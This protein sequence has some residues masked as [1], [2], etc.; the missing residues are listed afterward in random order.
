MLFRSD[1]MKKK[2][3]VVI[4]GAI[5]LTFFSIGYF[6]IG[7]PIV[8]YHNLQ[9]KF[10][11]TNLDRNTNVITLNEIVPFEWD[12]VYTFEPYATKEEI[13][14]IIG[15]DSNSIQETVSEGMVQLLFIKDKTVVSSVCAYAENIGYRIDFQSNVS[16]DDNVLFTVDTSSDVIRLIKQEQP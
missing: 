7:N 6:I 5:V 14:K 13:A 9:L 10:A 8:Y 11:V 1:K 15:F 2:M 3:Y 12:T 4:L 16:F